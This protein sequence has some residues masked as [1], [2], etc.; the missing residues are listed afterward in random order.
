[1]TL[2]GFASRMALLLGDLMSAEIVE[3]KSMERPVTFHFTRASFG[4]V[5]FFL[6]LLL[7]AG[8]AMGIWFILWADLSKT[9]LS[10]LS[11][12]SFGVVGSS[13]S[14]IRKIYKAAFDG[15]VVFID[16]SIES[17][18]WIATSLYLT[19]RP[20][21]SIPISFLIAISSVLSYTASSPDNVE[22]TRN[23]VYILSASGFAAGFYSGK[24]LSKIDE[25]GLLR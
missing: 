4:G 2:L 21:F 22:P 25:K 12:T 20:L 19:F 24:I 8:T 7:L 14:Y 16:K 17:R 18:F 5:I 11:A 23:L 6:S 13:I 3:Y 9:T 15:R 10:V 1:M